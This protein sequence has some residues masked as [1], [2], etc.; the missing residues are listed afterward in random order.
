MSIGS[1][2]VTFV[3]FPQPRLLQELCD[4]SGFVRLIEFGRLDKAAGAKRFPCSGDG[5]RVVVV[6][7]VARKVA[8]W[9]TW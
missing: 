4:N 9:G 3:L 7:V 6:V 5:R 2:S 1:P 8:R